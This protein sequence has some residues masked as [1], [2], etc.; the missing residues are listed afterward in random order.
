MNTTVTKPPQSGTVQ[1]NGQELYYEVH[2]E[3]P[4]LSW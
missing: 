2:G 1:T 3:G 4:A